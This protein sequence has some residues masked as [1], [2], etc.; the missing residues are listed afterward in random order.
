[1]GWKYSTHV[2][3]DVDGTITVLQVQDTTVFSTKT[4]YTERMIREAVDIEVHPNTIYR[5]DG[6]HPSRARKPLIHTVRGR[7][8]QRIQCRESLLGH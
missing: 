7:R 5:E 3:P 8:H 6:L 2:E 4:T 1:M